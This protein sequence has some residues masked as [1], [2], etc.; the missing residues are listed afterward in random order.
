[1]KQRCPIRIVIADDHCVVREGLTAIINREPEMKVIAEGRNW[2][3]A[4]Q[5]VLHH[6]PDLAIVDLHMPGVEG[7]KGIR[8]ILEWFSTARI[9][10][11]SAYDTEEEV[12][13]VI[14]AGASGYVLKGESSR[15]DLLQCIRAVCEGQV[16]IHPSAAAKLAERMNT[17]SLTNREKDILQM[18]VEGKS[19]KEIGSSLNVT[20]GTVKVHLN[21]IFA[22]LGVQ[23]RVAAVGVAVRRGIAR[24]DGIGPF[25]ARQTRDEEQAIR[26]QTTHAL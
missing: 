3:E 5:L 9:V 19:N 26:R 25:P 15:E 7:A 17:P 22:K 10:V 6:R 16:W 13:E 18:V 21:H 11:F 4:I 1:M 24:L 8:A 14:R 12:Y 23:G 20:E 2:M